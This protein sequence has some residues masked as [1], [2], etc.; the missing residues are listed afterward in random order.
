MRKTYWKSGDWSAICDVCG[1]KF[2]A[3]KL[4]LRWDG[5]RV[6]SSDWEVKHPQEFLRTPVETSVPSWTAP[7][8]EDVFETSIGFLEVLYFTDTIERACSFYRELTD[9][10][11]LSDVTVQLKGRIFTDTITMGSSGTITLPSYIESTYFA[12]DYMATSIT[13]S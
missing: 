3:S 13:I 8:S 11:S 2:K 1:F 6:C 7:E 10:I 12:S 9:T 5:L 4:K